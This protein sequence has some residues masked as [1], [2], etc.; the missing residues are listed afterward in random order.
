[1][2]IGIYWTL[3]CNGRGQGEPQAEREQGSVVKAI[4]RAVGMLT[5]VGVQV[6]VLCV[7]AMGYYIMMHD[8]SY[9]ALPAPQ[10]A[11]CPIYVHTQ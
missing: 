4:A 2:T 1:M 7:S 10:Q 9:I 3:W 11:V 8:T 5:T 6:L